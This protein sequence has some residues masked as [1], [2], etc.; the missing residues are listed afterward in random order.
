MAWHHSAML[1]LNKEGSMSRKFKLS[2]NYYDEDTKIFSKVNIK[3]DTGLTVLVGC[4][5]A[6][7]TT[8]LKQ[9]THSLKTKNIPVLFHSNFTNGERDLK[10]K[11]AFRSQF[12][13]VARIMSSSEGENIVN[14]LGFIAKEMG[15][16]S[17]D[18]PD[19]NEL[20]FL[21]DAID[22]GL[23][24]DNIIEF[25]EILIPLVIE[26]NNDKDIYFVISANEYEFARNEKCFDVMNGNYIS[27]DD[28]EDYRDFILR[29][30]EQ[31]DKRY[32]Q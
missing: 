11:A 31:K 13:V 30:K 19:A 9:I 25:K 8:L 26:N 5:G 24:I 32:D 27:F 4:N 22:S 17:R 23:S 12:D 16:M 21:F 10:S 15:R 2:N 18:N 7:K 29:S 3:I 20:W 14:V 6:G 1:F 28:Y